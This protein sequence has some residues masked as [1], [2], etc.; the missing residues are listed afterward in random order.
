MGFDDAVLRGAVLCAVRVTCRV[1]RCAPKHSCAFRVR[2][3]AVV[4]LGRFACSLNRFH[5]PGCRLTKKEYRPVDR[6]LYSYALAVLR[7][8]DLVVIIERFYEE[9]TRR[10]IQEVL[11][12]DVTDVQIE[13]NHQSRLKEDPPP[14]VLD[15]L[16]RENAF[17]VALYNEVA[18]WG[19]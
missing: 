9:R 4:V 8:F 12:Y 15:T 13:R 6:A 18:S 16:R 1:V 5:T 19:G 11:G 14:S 3:V 17:D 7:A 2:W 10:R